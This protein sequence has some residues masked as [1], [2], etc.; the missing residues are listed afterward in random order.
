MGPLKVYLPAFE[1]MQRLRTIVSE[2]RRALVLR[3]MVVATCKV[4]LALLE[5]LPW[6]FLLSVITAL[7]L[8]NLRVEHLFFPPVIATTIALQRAALFILANKVTCLPFLTNFKWII[9]KVMRLPSEVLPVMSID[10]LG[11][12]VFLV[13]GAPFSLEI[14]H[15]EICVPRHLMDQRCFNIVVWMR[16]WAVLLVFAILFCLRAKLGFVAFDMVQPLYFIVCIFALIILAIFN[17]T[18]IYIVVDLSSTPTLV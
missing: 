9:S 15:I 2:F 14:V 8:V 13:V 6:V 10:T 3:W 16:K 7:R 18:E 4:L 1:G 12:I 5:L 11:F 17:F